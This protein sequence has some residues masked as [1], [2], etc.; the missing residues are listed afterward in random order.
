MGKYR[1]WNPGLTIVRESNFSHRRYDPMHVTHCHI[2]HSQCACRLKMSQNRCNLSTL[3]KLLTKEE[4]L[5]LR[6]RTAIS[7]QQQVLAA[8]CCCGIHDMM[9]NAMFAREKR[10]RQ[11][12]EEEECSKSFSFRAKESC[13]TTLP[14]A[15]VG[16]NKPGLLHCIGC[17][18]LRKCRLY[19]TNKYDTK[20]EL[21]GAAR[22]REG[23]L[24]RQRRRRRHSEA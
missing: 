14:D 23:L 5:R 8:G 13:I 16:C 22:E 7:N 24:R 10:F 9:E 21:N 6:C 18:C 3:T 4:Q 20:R 2:S 19:S 11:K 17:V 12:E 1:L 15:D